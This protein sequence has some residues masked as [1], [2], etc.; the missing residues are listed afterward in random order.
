[1]VKVTIRDIAE[2]LGISHATV[3]RVLNGHGEGF[4]SAATRDRVVQAAREMGY[5][6]NA[7]ARAL[8]TGRT[9]VVGVWLPTIETPFY[10]QILHQLEEHITNHGYTLTL[11]RTREP[12]RSLS[13]TLGASAVD[14]VIAVDLLLSLDDA[15]VYDPLRHPAIVFVGVHTPQSADC[16]HVDLKSGMHEA[17]AHLL[18]AGCRRIAY[19]VHENM[20]HSGEA[21][22]DAYYSSLREAGRAPEVITFPTSSLAGA[23]QALTEYIGT[24][25]HPDGLLCQ[26]DDTAIG[27]FRALRDLELHVPRD[28]RLVGCDGIDQT[29]FFDPRLSTIQQ[30]IARM[31]SLAWQ[32]LERRLADSS[33]PPQQSSLAANLVIRDSS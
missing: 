20:A 4:I 30:P 6:R 17:F 27:A 12:F 28:V 2:Q 19:M 16:V 7:A 1:M 8:V 13:E 32:F 24:H 23:R 15:P 9:G 10:M 18:K 29:G 33:L 25:G 26:N 11:T 3:S 31:C 5:R 14:G 21:R 22:L